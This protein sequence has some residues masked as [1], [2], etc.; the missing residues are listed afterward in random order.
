LQV[1]AAQ[2]GYSAISAAN[3]FSSSATGHL[4]IQYSNWKVSF[5]GYSVDNRSADLPSNECLLDLEGQRL[6]SIEPGPLANAWAFAFDLGG[7]LEIW[8]SAEYAAGD[9]L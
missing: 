1:L 9:D 3:A 6:V 5:A 8:S 7:R 4:W 2:T